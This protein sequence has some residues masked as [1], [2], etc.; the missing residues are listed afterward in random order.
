MNDFWNSE[1]ERRGVGPCPSD[2]IP[3]GE[4]GNGCPL[5]CLNEA[6]GEKLHLLVRYTLKGVVLRGCQQCEVR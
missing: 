1:G 3:Q 6:T 5:L 4:Q 2:W